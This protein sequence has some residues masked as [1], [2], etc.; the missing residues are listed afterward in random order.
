MWPSLLASQSD[1]LKVAPHRDF[2]PHPIH[3][4]IAQKHVC[5]SIWRIESHL[6]IPTMQWNYLFRKDFCRKRQRQNKDKDK[7]KEWKIPNMCYIFGKQRMQGYQIWP[8]HQEIFIKFSQNFPKISR[9]FSDIF[10]KFSRNLRKIFEKS[11]KNLRK[12]SRNFRKIF[13]KSSRNLRKIFMEFS[14][15]FHWIFTEFSWNF[16][17]IFTKFLWYQM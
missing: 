6:K 8:F 12:S 9:N 11:S 15:N 17:G 5:L 7:D 16:H 4:L 14:L 10:P 13:E 2:Q 3:P 1:A